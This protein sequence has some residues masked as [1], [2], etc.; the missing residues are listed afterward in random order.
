MWI[1]VGIPALVVASTLFFYLG[2]PDVGDLKSKNPDTTAL[3]I[4]RYR[5]AQKS[6]QEFKLRQKWVDFDEIPKLLQDSIRV[7]ED[8]GFYRHQGVDFTELRIVLKKSWEKGKLIRG[9]STITQ[10]LAKNLYLTT[11]KS[12]FRKIKEYFI[13][14]RLEKALPKNRIFH[15]YLNVIEFGPGIFGVQAASRYFFQKD[16]G[17]LGLEEIV[18]LTAVIPKPIKENPTGSSSWLKW[19][20]RWILDTLKRY[21]YIDPQQ[22]QAAIKVFQ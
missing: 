2:L 6:G 20:S 3:M 19:K 18:R 9:A 5:E 13:A 16:V 15:L 17:Q 14:R 22:H 8:A 10:Q 12:I 4:Q 21:K 11:D 1:V 7:T